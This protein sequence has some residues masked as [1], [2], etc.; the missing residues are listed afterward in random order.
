MTSASLVVNFA[1]RVDPQKFPRHLPITFTDEEARHLIR[2]HID[3]VV[4]ELDVRI[5]A[6]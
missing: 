2:P 4:V 3:A 6:M 1:E 5:S